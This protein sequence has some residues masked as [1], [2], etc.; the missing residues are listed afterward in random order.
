MLCSAP[1]YKK[2]PRFARGRAP[3]GFCRKAK[4]AAAKLPF[5]SSPRVYGAVM[6]PWPCPSAWRTRRRPARPS[7]A[8]RS[9]RLITFS[10]STCSMASF[11]PSFLAQ[12]PVSVMLSVAPAF[13]AMTKQRFATAIWMPAA[14]SSR[15]LALAHQ[16][17]DL[18]LGENGALRG[19]GDDVLGRQ[20]T[21]SRTRAGSARR[22]SGHGLE[23]AAGTCGALVVHSEVLDRAVRVDG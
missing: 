4:G 5:C 9:C 17:D 3:G 11:R 23:E 1:S 14:I 6:R 13:F 18:G 21:G 16:G 8:G 15:G 12:P 19:D 10:F 7:A 2:T 20:A 22:R